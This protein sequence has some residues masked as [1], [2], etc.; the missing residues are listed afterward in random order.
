MTAKSMAIGMARQLVLAALASAATSAWACGGL[1]CD[2]SGAGGGPPLPVDQN[3]ERIVFVVDSAAGLVCSHVQIQYRGA[4]ESFAWVVPVPSVPTIGES[5]TDLFRQ[6]DAVAAL[7]VLPP[8]Y[9]FSNCAGVPSGSSA[10]SGGSGCGC[11]TDVENDSAAAGD[12]GIGSGEPP[13]TV[14]A[15]VVTAN[16]EA[17]VV[18]SESTDELITWLRDNG[19]NFSDNM[20][21]AVA[22]YVDEHLKFAAFRLREGRTAQDI[23]PIVL[24]YEASAPAIPLRLTAVAAQPMM[25][26][27]VHILGDATFGRFG[28]ESVAPDPDAIVFDN[29]TF[30]TNYFEWVARQ[31]DE[32]DGANW[33]LEYTGGH[34][35]DLPLPG[36]DKRTTDFPWLTR[37]YT[38]LSAQ[39]MTEDPIFV[40]GPGRN[41][42]AAQIDLSGQA[43]IDGCA[44]PTAPSACFDNYCGLGATCAAAAGEPAHCL[45]R[46]GEVA[47]PVTGP[48]GRSR[49]TCT[50]QESPLGITDEAAGARGSFDPCNQY[51]CGSGQCALKNGFPA[52]VCDAG[53]GAFVDASGFVRCGVVDDDTPRFG[54]GAGPESIVAPPLEAAAEGLETLEARTAPW[55]P[56]SVPWMAGLLAGRFVFVR[57][58]RRS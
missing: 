58:R 55:L 51:V 28:G 47:Q 6:L 43:P 7:T 42:A 33:V 48:D 21:P 18:G 9:D 22:A 50:P 13:V 57:R 2:T 3:G 12:A 45:C 26:I 23:T 27:G 40:P 52:C 15:E 32:S 20:R 46:G 17:V 54:P 4:P 39:H 30:Q 24:C 25:G 41:T 37:F 53:A 11:G 16:Y 31:A 56:S 34:G 8:P 1:F 44:N 5:D 49:V 29:T 10:G 14:Y 19:F 35:V 36:M 38:R